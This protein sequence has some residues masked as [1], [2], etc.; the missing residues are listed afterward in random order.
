ML[1]LTNLFNSGTTL[2]YA[3]NPLQG[4]W[5]S[6]LKAYLPLLE[7]GFAFIMLFVIVWMMRYLELTQNIF[8][9]RIIV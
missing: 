6:A 9:W 2:L 4:N 3:A 1:L 5:T 7:W 8:S